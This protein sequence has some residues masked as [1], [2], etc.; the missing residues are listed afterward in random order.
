MQVQAKCLCVRV[1][2]FW[3]VVHKGSFGR[4]VVLRHVWY[5]GK[6]YLTNWYTTECAWYMYVIISTFSL[7]RWWCLLRLRSFWSRAFF[8]RIVSSCVGQLLIY[9]KVRII[10]SLCLNG[11]TAHLHLIQLSLS[12]IVRCYQVFS[13]PPTA[14]CSDI[15]GKEGRDMGGHLVDRPTQ[16]IIGIFVVNIPIQET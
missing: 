11:I 7:S 16:L 8:T 12:T 15:R 4:G 1:S 5:K 6:P 9:S 3:E 13:S 14:K 10:S 2:P